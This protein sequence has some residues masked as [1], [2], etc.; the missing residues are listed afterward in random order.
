MDTTGRT[1]TLGLLALGT[2]LAARAADPL[3]ADRR[4]AWLAAVT[5]GVYSDA[6]NWTGGELP[7]NGADGKYGVI[8]FQQ[9]DV[10][11]RA[12]AEGLVENSGTIFLGT[13]AGRHTLTLD[14]RGT[15]W[16]KT[17]VKSVNNWW[18]SPFAANVGGQH[19]FNFEN[20][21]NNVANTDPVWEFADALFTWTS[22]AATRQTFDL[23][24]G[25]F[26]FSKDLYLGSAGGTVDFF[27]HPGARLESGAW[28]AFRQRGN[29]RTTT[30]VLGGRHTFAD[31]MLKD[32]NAD[33]GSTWFV[34]TNDAA[35]AVRGSLQLGARSTQSQ[36][37][38][39]HGLLDLFGTS[40]MEVTNAAYLGAGSEIF[41]NLRNQGT[42][43]LHDAATFYAHNETFVGRTQCATGIVTVA[44]G[45]AYLT[46]STASGGGSVYLGVGSNAVGHLTVQDD[47]RFA[48]GGVLKLGSGPYATGV[49]TVKDR[50]RVTCGLKTGNWLTLATGAESAFGRLEM[51]DDA[52]LTLGDGACVEMTYGS[53]AAR[54]EIALAGRAR[55]EGGQSSYVTNKC[56]TA[57]AAS[58][59]LADEAVLSMRAVFGA[60]PETE[61]A[62]LG[63]AADGGTLVA[64]GAGPLPVPYLSGCRATLGAR[65]LTFDT[66]RHD[67]VID[68]AFTAADGAPEATFTKTGPGTLTVRRDSDHPRTHV[69]AGRLAF[70]AD[71]TR[72]GRRLSF[73][74]GV[75]L[76]LPEEGCLTADEIAFDGELCL[77]A[78]AASELG[79]P[80][81][82]LKLTAPLTGQQLARLVVVNG[83]DGK[84]YA[85]TGAEDGTV[86]LTVTEAVAGARTWTGAAGTSWHEA[87]NWEPAAVPTGGDDVTVAA[88]AASATL[89]VAD[90]AAVRS[91]AVGAGASV[92]VT[93]EGPIQ[94]GAGVDVSEGAS[95]DWA[96]PLLGVGGTFEKRGA[97]EL[98]V[99]GDQG[100]TMQSDW[101]LVG[102]RTVFTSG[103][104]LGADTTS[105]AALTLSNNTFRYTGEAA[106]V[107]RP[108]TLLGEL[109]CVFDIVGD[110]TFR[111]FRMAFVQGDAG[112]VKTGA[113]TLTLQV[114][115]GTTTLSVWKASPR[116][117][118]VDVTGVFAPSA[119]GEVAN[120]DGAGQFSVLDGRVEI[121]GAGKAASTVKQEHQ[122]SIGGSGWPSATAPELRLRDVTF[123]QGGNNGCHMLMD[124]QTVAGSKG[125]CLVLDHADMTCNGLYVGF[126]KKNGNAETVRPSLA[127]TNGTLD[128]TWLLNIP[129][130]GG[131]GM[132]PVVRVGAGGRIRRATYTGTG[133]V[134]FSH[135]LDARFEDGGTLEVALPQCVYFGGSA[136]GEVVFARGG[137]LTTSR[138]LAL[139]GQTEAAL[140]FDGGFAAFTQDGGISAGTPTATC[141]RADAGGGE[142]RVGA[143]VSHALALPL[144]G[145]GTF[146]KTGA[147]TLVL[148]N[149][150]AIT[151]S[152][153][154]NWNKIFSFSE[155]GA[156]T[157]KLVNAGGLVVAEGTVR[158][159]PGTVPERTRVAG[160]GTLSGVFMSLTLAV[161]PGAMEALTFAD[162]TAQTVF[163]DFG[164]A[165]DAAP[166]P[167]GTRTAV[168]HLDDAARFGAVAWKGGSVGAGR[169]VKFTCE[170]Q[171]VVATV[172]SGGTMLILR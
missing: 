55:L 166:L 46:R 105:A 29:A 14:T 104:A 162:L 141:L 150:L 2:V 43:T 91:L 172:T 88:S 62:G 101:R 144:A 108:V 161:E 74:R 68:Q 17:G 84:A 157:P 54:A 147:G 33:G 16:R 128:I 145:T 7:A 97:G 169:L 44:G 72:F 90:L 18:C 109:P 49:M 146:T 3:D 5:D 61:E 127:I 52:V 102:G 119:A 154:A 86:S 69:A 113:G 114:P 21:A 12:P 82:V 41:P 22:E 156:T 130:D 79:T 38:L 136:R 168:A 58:I 71:A 66:G 116:K 76:V 89:A 122:G 57:G 160:T 155:T 47:G 106:A 164:V 95:L 139:N 13:G 34:L 126:N 45:A 167:V 107:R 120:W 117:G 137:G 67:V 1:W 24:S 63:L 75:C 138:F 39:S 93:G 133:G 32:G 23:L 118:N 99:R 35:V 81:A 51:A 48:C 132:A 28:A 143:G 170:G 129:A 77:M 6:A 15:F 59:S 165:A 98:T 124:Q 135:T 4:V 20:C 171:T 65:G 85:F 26:T 92:A 25:T 83:E 111:D 94:V 115:S 121:V 80:R 103:A 19:V 140:V 30:T 70:A 112:L 42:I 64:A 96:V 37:G 110:L 153:D 100:A 9:N 31:L 60:I 158:C 40:R 131:A 8:S 125:A 123:V 53:A 36:N 78:P 10:T 152:Q 163:V 27:I 11:V 134:W 149:D 73:A 56:P 159:L 142:L 87:G 148:T 151:V 50:G